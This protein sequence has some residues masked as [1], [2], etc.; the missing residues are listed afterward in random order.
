MDLVRR[1]GLR[2]RVTDPS[3]GTILKMKRVHAPLPRQLLTGAFLLLLFLP[4]QGRA[5]TSDGYPRNTDIDIL[6]YQFRFTLSDESDVSTGTTRI[7]VQF[8]T[9]GVSEFTLDRNV[10][11]REPGRRRNGDGRGFGHPARG[12]G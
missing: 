8:R 1:H 7:T 5:Q 11:L 4:V 12:K 3:E 9:A 6:H 10:R 2:S